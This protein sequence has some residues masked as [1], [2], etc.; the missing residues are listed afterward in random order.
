[1][2][3]IKSKKFLGHDILYHVQYI[4]GHI[5]RSI[6][7]FV[8]VSCDVRYDVLMQAYAKKTEKLNENR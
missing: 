1:M 4:S 6:V 8:G 5:I 7:G 2:Q 3:T